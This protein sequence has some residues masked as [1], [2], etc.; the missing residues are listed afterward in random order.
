MRAADAVLSVFGR[1]LFGAFA[2]LLGFWYL[3]I[4][5]VGK[6]LGYDLDAGGFTDGK[7][8]IREVTGLFS[9][10]L[11]YAVVL[12]LALQKREPTISDEDATALYS[13]IFIVVSLVTLW[14]M[15][16]VIRAPAE[17]KTATPPKHAYDWASIQWTRVALVSGSVIVGAV[18]L[19]AWNHA[20]PNQSFSVEVPIPVRNAGEYRK[21]EKLEGLLASVVLEP[22]VFKGEGVP[23]ELNLKVA[24]PKEMAKEWHVENVYGFTAEKLMERQPVRVRDPQEKTPGVSWWLVEGLE[25]GARHEYFIY[26]L[27]NKGATEIPPALKTLKSELR[28]S[29][30]VRGK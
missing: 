13:S 6:G 2:L 15:Y 8:V 23:G 10:I 21:D 30:F 20:L 1:L 3:V 26:V 12:T 19:L 24:L 14:G 9:L 16:L 27:P 25:K 17:F 7:P 5:L 29:A 11:S 28:V 22:A 4:W 18:F